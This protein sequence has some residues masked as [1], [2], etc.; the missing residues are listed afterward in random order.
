MFDIGW[1]E[2]FLIAVV[3]LVVIGPKD[4]PVAMRTMARV[5]SRIRALSR[6]FQRS[7][8]D[9]MREAELDE[10]RQ[11][12]DRAGR[13]DIKGKAARMVDPDGRLGREFDLA[14]DA[15]SS[16]SPDNGPRSGDGEA[17]APP[18]AA[19]AP[20][21]AYGERAV[22]PQPP[23]APPVAPPVAPLAPTAGA[24]EGVSA[25]PVPVAP[26]RP[27]ADRVPGSETSER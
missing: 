20:R 13:I 5:L 7:V 25:S 18:P 6:E 3:A 23:E 10:I 11:Q 9:I 26:L 27:P 24:A 22:G 1:Q 15:G 17:A 4:L 16:P 14:T 2:L 19:M 21:A 8:S 12:V